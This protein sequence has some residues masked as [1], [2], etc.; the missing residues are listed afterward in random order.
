MAGSDVAKW[1]R[2]AAL[3]L[4]LAGMAPALL[5]AAIFIWGLDAGDELVFFVS[6]MVIP[7]AGAF[8]VWRFGTWAKLVAILA[9]VVT[10]M[11]LFWTAFGLTEP[12]SFFDFV[13]GLLLI[14]GCLLA[15]GA[16]IAALVANK[17]G[18]VSSAPKGGEK[19]GIAIAVV[20]VVLAAVI[21]GALNLTLRSSA[22]AAGAQAAVTFKNFEF[23]EAGYALEGGTQVFVRNDDPFVHTFTIDELGIDERLLGGGS[24]IIDIPAEPGTYVVYCRPH[25]VDPQDPS[26][27]DMAAAFTVL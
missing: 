15:I 14:P 16:S 1:T 7:L 6:A 23:S 9:A 11:A 21:S 2:L 27:V 25:T 17:R 13:P 4:L 18:C 20:T 10:A 3:G 26:Q 19:V 12:A 22:D 5:L 24:T 8:L